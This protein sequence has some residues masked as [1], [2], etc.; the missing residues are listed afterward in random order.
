MNSE[1]PSSSV[2]PGKPV[3]TPVTVSTI[4]KHELH[5]VRTSWWWF[6]AL[7][8]MLLICGIL[9][10]IFPA[11]SSWAAV[12]VLSIVLLVA[13]V[14]TIIGSFWAGRWGGFLVEMLVGMIYV[15]ASLIMRRDPVFTVAIITA[16]VAVAFIVMGLFRIMA[17]LVIHFPQW[18]WSLLNG[19]ITLLLGIIILRDFQDGN[20]WIIGL[21]VGIEMLFAGVAWIML[22]LE[23]RRIPE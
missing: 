18:G 21:L 5:H 9:A 15:A 1:S 17:T 14:A 16:F 19:C 20:W 7:G 11:I 4:A 22:A 6:Y 23:I 12:K 8:V 3:V 10:I 13:G 2:G